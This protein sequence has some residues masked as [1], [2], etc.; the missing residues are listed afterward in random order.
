MAAY[1]AYETQIEISRWPVFVVVGLVVLLLAIVYT[2]VR[3]RKHVSESD[4]RICASC[5][6]PHPTHAGFC[7]KCGKKLG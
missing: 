1:Q 7:R 3:N 5:A 6:T 2:A 4:V